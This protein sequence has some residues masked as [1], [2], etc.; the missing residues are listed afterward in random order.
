MDHSERPLSVTRGRISTPPSR[1]FRCYS[2]GKG[3]DSSPPFHLR[4]IIPCLSPR[5]HCDLTRSPSSVSVLLRTHV[6][7]VPRLPVRSPCGRRTTVFPRIA[8]KPT[9]CEGGDKEIS[10]DYPQA[11]P[12]ERGPQSETKV[13]VSGIDPR[14]ADARILILHKIEN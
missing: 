14:T 13:P 2:K 1:T 5:L 8:Q 4:C 9:T 11:P 7:R 6:R 10:Q 3:R 12:T